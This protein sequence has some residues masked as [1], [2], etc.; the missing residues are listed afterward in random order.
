MRT[1]VITANPQKA[2]YK[3][4]FDGESYA[5]VEKIA[6]PDYGD[7]M[8]VKDS[9]EETKVQLVLIP[10]T[11]NNQKSKIRSIVKEEPLKNRVGS[12]V[13]FIIHAH[14]YGIESDGFIQDS[15]FDEYFNRV[16]YYLSESGSSTVYK[17][18]INTTHSQYFSRI[19][20]KLFGR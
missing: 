8:L 18:L 12:D 13:Y 3:Q 17:H 19:E 4:F 10:A 6:H 9:I 16:Y 1:Y 15:E 11:Y 5:N 7:V 14:D 20:D 2:L